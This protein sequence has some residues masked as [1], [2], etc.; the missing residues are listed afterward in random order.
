[1]RVNPQHISV[2]R[3]FQQHYVFRVPRYQRGYSWDEPQVADFIHDISRCY[4][5]R[6]SGTPRHHF[7]GGV[8][9]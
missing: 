3:L 1:M 4:R 2:G 8:V 5:A 7:F 9:W 6:A